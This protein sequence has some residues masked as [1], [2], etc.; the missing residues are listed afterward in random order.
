[1]NDK[2]FLT[3]EQENYICELIDDWYLEWKEKITVKGQ[4]DLHRLGM[5]KEM[6]KLKVCGDKHELSNTR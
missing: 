6:L 5:A 1:M 4:P 3:Y 2:N